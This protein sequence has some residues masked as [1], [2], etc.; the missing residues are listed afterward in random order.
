[1]GSEEVQEEC[2]EVD[3]EKDLVEDVAISFVALPTASKNR[4]LE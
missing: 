3:V 2:L 1:V 4:R